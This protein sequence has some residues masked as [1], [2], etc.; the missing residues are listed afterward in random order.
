MT[1][2][3]YEKHKDKMSPFKC[4]NGHTYMA[5]NHSCFFCKH[6]DL[7]WDYTNGPYAA[8]CDVGGSPVTDGLSGDCKLYEQEA[9]NG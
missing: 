7:F 9:D 5:F 1:K 6:C 3:E 2:E 8:S 4:E